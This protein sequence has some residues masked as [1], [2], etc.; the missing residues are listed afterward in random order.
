MNYKTL[1]KNRDIISCKINLTHIL[2]LF[3]FLSFGIFGSLTPS[4]ELF[5]KNFIYHLIFELL[6]FTLP[7]FF[8]FYLRNFKPVFLKIKFNLK[9]T[10]ISLVSLAVFTFWDLYPVTFGL[11]SDEQS[12]VMSAHEHARKI[13]LLTS[14]IF[15]KIDPL[16]INLLIRFLSFFICV[17]VVLNFYIFQT[18]KLGILLIYTCVTIFFLRII[19]INLG[20]HMSPHPSMNLIPFLFTGTF[21]GMSPIVFKLLILTIFVFWTVQLLDEQKYLNTWFC[22][23]LYAMLIFTLP[24]LNELK[25]TVEPSLWTFMLFFYVCVTLMKNGYKNYNKIIMITILACFFRQPAFLALVPIFM[26]EFFFLYKRIFKLNFIFLLLKKYS[27]LFLFIP[28]LVNSIFL[29]SGTTGSILQSPYQQ[30]EHYY[31]NIFDVYKYITQSIPLAY[32]LLTFVFFMFMLIKNFKLF[33]I[34]INFFFVLL[35]IFYSII[36][37][38]WGLAKYQ[39]EYMIPFFLIGLLYVSKNFSHQILKYLLI[40]P[41]ISLNI[42]FMI[43]PVW[44][45]YYSKGVSEPSKPEI[46]PGIKYNYRSFISELNEQ[47]NLKTTV[48]LGNH[49]KLYPILSSDVNVEDYKNVQENNKLMLDAIQFDKNSWN[50]K[51]LEFNHI[52]NIIIESIPKRD[53]LIK[54]LIEMNWKVKKTLKNLDHNTSTFWL[55]RSSG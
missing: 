36:P 29:G 47:N 2:F 48:F 15:E 22:K 17:Y 24:I 27:P 55:V 10:Y 5:K 44:K 13:I 19:F 18:K 54:I 37:S 49:Y 32:L 42:Y 38:A 28:Y 40:L 11:F 46:Y 45:T 1:L 3:Y 9:N 51:N 53:E 23:Y 20:G 14:N 26:S 39:A 7:I 50:I 52:D 35:F 34:F 8:Y 16:S 4:I 33:F 12:Y 6:I 25:H 43:Y 30:F 41:L 31:P 21:L